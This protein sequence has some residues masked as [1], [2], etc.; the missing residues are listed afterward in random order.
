MKKLLSTCL[1]L[2][3]LAVFGQSVIIEEPLLITP[4][5]RIYL[6]DTGN[7]A[8]TGDSLHPLQT[9]SAAL[10]R[11]NLITTGMIGNVYTEVVAFEGTYNEIFRQTLTDFQIGAKVMNVSLRGKEGVIIDGNG[12]TVNPGGGMVYLLGSNISVKNIK[13]QNSSEIGLRFGFNYN[14]T[15]INSHDILIDSVEVSATKSHGILVGIGSLNANGSSVL[16][17]RAKRFKLTNC[18]VHDAVNYNTPQSSWGSAI[19]FWNTSHNLASNNHVHDNSGEGIDFDYCDTAEVSDNQLHDNYANIYLDKMEYAHIHN[20]LIFNQSKVVSGILMGIEAFTG[21][22]TN[23]FIKDVYI[24][25]NIIL[26]TMG[27]AVWQGIYSAIQ[28]GY[29]QNIH[30]RQNTLIGKQVGNGAMVSFNYETFLGQPVANV[31]HSNIFIERNIIA[32]NVDS[33]NNQKL[34]SAPLNPQPGLTTGYNL[35][36]I[37]P[38]FAFNASS[39]QINNLVPDYVNPMGNMLQDLTPNSNLNAELIMSAPNNPVVLVDYIYSLRQSVNTNV[40]AVELNE[41]LKIDG[42]Y[43]SNFKVYPNP[44]A[45]FLMISVDNNHAHLQITCYNLIGS[46]IL[47]CTVSENEPIDFRNLSNGFYL[48]HVLSESGETFQTTIQ[49]LRP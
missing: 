17:P 26:N 25:N 32:A 4:T 49:V 27:I 34:L 6:D 13:I 30:I 7:N 9:F 22:I 35:F 39:D 28:N 2:G 33:L 31:S 46:E 45:D 42:L 38:G 12:I 44:T 8:N 19:K 36:N 5:H 3:S 18:H 14:G 48:L 41:N 37:T 24:E 29:F 15:V 23:H 1:Y 11:L 20:N 47:S 21:Y 40:G 16:I 10:S 43:A